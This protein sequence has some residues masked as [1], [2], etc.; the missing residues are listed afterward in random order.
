M[1]PISKEGFTYPSVWRVERARERD[2]KI[3]REKER[4][5]ER[6]RYSSVYV[7]CVICRWKKGKSRVVCE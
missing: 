6:D 2:R 5:R 1:T 3:E 7:F 4:E